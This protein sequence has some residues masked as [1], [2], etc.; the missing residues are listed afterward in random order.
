M[1]CRRETRMEHKVYQICFYGFLSPRHSLVAHVSTNHLNKSTCKAQPI[2]KKK[3]TMPVKYYQFFVIKVV[4]FSIFLPKNN[5]DHPVQNIERQSK[6]LITLLFFFT[7]EIF[8][9]YGTWVNLLFAINGIVVLSHFCYKYHL[10]SKCR[11]AKNK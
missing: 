3:H 9:F 1:Q 4:N 7:N 10:T 5:L 11:K 8:C 6:K 2:V